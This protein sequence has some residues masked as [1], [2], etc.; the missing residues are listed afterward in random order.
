MSYTTEEISA[1]VYEITDKGIKATRKQRLANWSDVDEYVDDLASGLGTFPGRSQLFL[2][3]VRIQPF[4]ENNISGLD[5]YGRAKCGSGAEI[6]LEYATRE[7][8][9]QEPPDPADPTTWMSHEMEVQQQYITHAQSSLKW[10][11]DSKQVPDDVLPGFPVTIVNHS[12]TWRNYGNPPFATWYDYVGKV[13][14]ASF[15]GHGEET[16][17]FS[18]FSAS[19]QLKT[20]GSIDYEIKMT[21]QARI[22]HKSGSTIG[23]NHFLREDGSW[24]RI[25]DK[26]DDKI[27][28][29]ANLNDLFA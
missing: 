4:D 2:Q 17:L 23:W 9:P 14:S 22:V 27:I 21:F 25:V 16:V 26:G 28:D 18:G 24:D 15:L 20:D 3:V 8:D 6:I 12:I 29:D 5:R 19:K 1:P 10:Q 11:S 7:A 13:N